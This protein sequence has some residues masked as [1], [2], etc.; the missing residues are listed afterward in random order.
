[1]KSEMLLEADR[2]SMTPL[3]VGLAAITLA[4]I[5][6]ISTLGSA[7]IFQRRLVTLAEAKAI[8]A[9]TDGPE[10]PSS[11]ALQSEKVE[12]LDGQ[13]VQVR[14]CA[15]WQPPLRLAAT[16]AFGNANQSICASGMSRLGK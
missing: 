4:L 5:L 1:M 14:L 3:M 8:S 13:T 6:T 16:F 2:G 10:I 7:F 11:I 15:Q 9:I 12:V